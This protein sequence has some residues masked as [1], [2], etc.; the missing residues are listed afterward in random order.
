M[1]TQERGLKM[2]FKLNF[3]SS[4]KKYLSLLSTF[5]K[6]SF[7]ADLEFRFNFIVLMATEII[8]Y[9]SN[10]LLF[11]V[12]Y[13]HTPLLAGWNHQQMRVF[14]F[15]SLFIDSIYMVLWNDNFSNFAEEVRKGQLDLLLT[16]PVNPLFMLTTKKI[17]V[18]HIPC[19]FITGFGLL[20]SLHNI[21]DFNY[22][23]LFWMFL[24]IPAGL[25][26]IFCGRMV[27]NTTMILFE[28]ADF[29]QYVWYSLF[30]LGMRPDGIYQSIGNGVFRFSLIFIFP[31]A[32]IA[33]IP[34]RILIE[35]F[36][37]VYVI[38]LFIMPFILIYLMNKYWNYGIKNYVSAS[39]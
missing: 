39:S 24:T 18:A 15:M 5:F 20:W 29:L 6:V 9:A 21:P 1:N 36:Q 32:M 14:V 12:I 11:E 30:R 22:A 10:L 23:S 37:P 8:W 17:S 13:N 27:L 2:N 38:W 16:K 26:V 33:S 35:P 19:L 28:R 31:F 4:L 34:T 7:I 25:T 3:I